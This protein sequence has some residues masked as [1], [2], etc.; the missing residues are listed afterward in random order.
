DLAASEDALIKAR[1]EWEAALAEAARKR[2]VTD[3]NEKPSRLRQAALNLG[4]LDQ[5]LGEIGKEKVSVQGTFNA[6]GARGLASEGP[7]ER[8]AKATEE[9]AKNTKRLL[10]EAKQAGLSFS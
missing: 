6:L 3:F 7:A 1:Q 8:T 2:D 4:G 9:T 10:N 5:V